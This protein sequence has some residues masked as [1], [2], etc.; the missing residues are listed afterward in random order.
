MDYADGLN[1]PDVS[2][3]IF[4]QEP[5]SNPF[6]A[7]QYRLVYTSNSSN[8]AEDQP[9]PLTVTD[10]EDLSR[11]SAGTR[12][13]FIGPVALQ[14]GTYLVGIS[15]AAYQPRTRVLTPF[16]VS[17]INS[18]RRIVDED[19]VAG[20]TTAEPPVV[21]NFL[22][23]ENVGATGVLNSATF[24]LGEYSAAD[25]PAVYLNYTHGLA[26]LKSW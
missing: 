14:E 25:Q 1:R 22:P 4:R 10:V 18:I 21:Q 7:F 3:N 5:S 19:Y 8:V 23:R 26:I 6:E 12:D 20:V 17:P 24:D 15:S 13:A 11:G 2:I 16:D 9:R